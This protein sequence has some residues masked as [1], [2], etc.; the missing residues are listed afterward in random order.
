MRDFVFIDDVVAVNLWFFD[1]PD[2]S[3]IYNL[4]TGRAPAFNDVAI[5]V[6]NTMRQIDGKEALSLQDAAAQ[7]LIEYI[8][9]PDALRAN[10][11]PTPRPTWPPCAPPDATTSSPTYKVVCKV[12]CAIWPQSSDFPG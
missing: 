1:H 4:G 7:G 11:K 10:T 9:F 5:S 12:M 6:V 8:A 3:G 2:Q